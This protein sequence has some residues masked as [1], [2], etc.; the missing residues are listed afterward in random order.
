MGIWLM[1]QSS[2]GGQR[3]FPVHKPTTI[4]GS[5]MTCD[6]RVPIPAVSRKH[7]QIH[8][9]GDRATLIDLQSERGTYHNGQPVEKAELA[10]DD[11]LTVGPVTFV[12]RVEHDC[13]PHNGIS[14]V[15]EIVIERRE[16]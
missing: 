15:S 1:M 12:V 11:T 4:I 13:A 6:V 3:S 7:C 9:E 2:D 14:H 5:E 8:V 16:V 10:H